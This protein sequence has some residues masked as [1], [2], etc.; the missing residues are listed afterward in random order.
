MN[1]PVTSLR[2]Y[3]RLTIARGWLAC[4]LLS[5]RLLAADS[6]DTSTN[7]TVTQRWFDSPGTAVTALQAATESKRERSRQPPSAGEALRLAM[8]HS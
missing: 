4:G 7:A 5:V 3:F 6:V 1:H 8:Q 2:I